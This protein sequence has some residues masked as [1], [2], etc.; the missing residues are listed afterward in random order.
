MYVVLFWVRKSWGG[1]GGTEKHGNHALFSCRYLWISKILFYLLDI[2]RLDFLVVGYMYIVYRRLLVC[3]SLSKY[4]L[5]AIK[6][7]FN[8]VF[9]YNLTKKN[10]IVSLLYKTDSIIE[11]GHHSTMVY[12]SHVFYCTQGL[13]SDYCSFHISLSHAFW[14]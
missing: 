3:T 7:S 11:L 12:H 8:I 5:A 4:F 14:S 6:F 9:G 13:F 2:R 1:G 10:T